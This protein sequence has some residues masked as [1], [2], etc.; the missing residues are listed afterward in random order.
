LTGWQR[1]AGWAGMAV[2]RPMQLE[3]PSP[4]GT[5]G[6]G[7]VARVV[8]GSAAV[9]AQIALAFYYLGLPIFTVPEPANYA[10]GVA[11]VAETV[12][13]I[14]LAIRHPWSAPIV[15]VVALIAFLLIFE[16]GKMNL[17]WGA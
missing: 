4:M 3:G 14:W 9:F 5:V 6:I 1:R 2:R 11:W 15:P 16:Y 8:I 10:L 7:R 13:A 17:G 12:I